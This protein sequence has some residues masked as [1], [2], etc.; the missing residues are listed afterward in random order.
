MTYKY[1]VSR[2]PLNFLLL[3]D[4]KSCSTNAP[5]SKVFRN[6]EHLFG[7]TLQSSN[8]NMNFLQ[9]FVGLSSLKLPPIPL[10]QTHLTFSKNKGKIGEFVLFEKKK[11]RLVDI[12]S[13]FMNRYIETSG[14]ETQ[15]LS[16]RNKD[17]NFSHFRLYLC[18]A[19]RT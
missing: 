9:T 5:I 3:K 8:L 19:W 14:K 11:L 10:C 15:A 17:V 13:T 12:H 4:V 7:Q 1:E 16:S 6:L 2:K 18:R